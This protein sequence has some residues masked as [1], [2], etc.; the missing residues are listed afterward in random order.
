MELGGLVR[1]SHFQNLDRYNNLL[2]MSVH[3]YYSI[4]VMYYSNL[5]TIFLQRLL[6]MS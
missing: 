1:V 3:N 4:R 5:Q 6:L 2:Y